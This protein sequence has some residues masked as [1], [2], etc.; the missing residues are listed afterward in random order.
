MFFDQQEYTCAFGMFCFPEFVFGNLPKQP[1]QI[2]CD[3]YIQGSTASSQAGITGS[4]DC[5]DS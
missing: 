3:H 2:G 5:S 4:A 1:D